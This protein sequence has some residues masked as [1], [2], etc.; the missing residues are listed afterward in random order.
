MPTTTLARPVTAAETAA[1]LQRELGDQYHVTP[2]GHGSLT[3]RHGAAF[4]TV[5]LDPHGDSTAFRVHG[6]GLILG[7]IVNELTIARRVARAISGGLTS[8]D[9]T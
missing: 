1:A 6:G 4:A 2:R 7:R 3:V 8:P 5:H 9:E